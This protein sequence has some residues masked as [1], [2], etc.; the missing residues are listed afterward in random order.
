MLKE[1]TRKTVLLTNKTCKEIQKKAN[2]YTNGNISEY[3]RLIIDK[4]L[5]E[6]K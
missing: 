1:G 5:A 4:H 3:L 6:S 2:Q